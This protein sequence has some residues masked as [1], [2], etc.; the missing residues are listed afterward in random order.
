[1]DIQPDQRPAR[2]E[3][4]LDSYEF[5]LFT[6]GMVLGAL[7]S[8]SNNTI[9]NGATLH[10]S[11]SGLSRI[12]SRL[13]RRADRQY[14]NPNGTMILSMTSQIRSYLSRQESDNVS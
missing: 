2:A 4:M 5:H 13:E 3:I 1:M 7:F 10:L 11:H 12:C 9:E 6:K 14:L 8:L